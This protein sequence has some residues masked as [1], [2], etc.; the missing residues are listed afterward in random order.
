VSVTVTPVSDP[1]VANNDS[2]STVEDTS[3]L[4]DVAAND[5]DA[6]GDLDPTTANTSCNPTCSGP[7]NGT[8]VN[9]GNGTFTYTPDPGYQGG[10]S[11]V[12]EI[13]DAG[14]LCATASVAIT[15][16][17]ATHVLVGAGDIAWCTRIEDDQTADLL[18]NIPGT[19]FTTGDNA[20]PT[21]STADF[22]NCYD[23]TWGRPVD[24]ESRLRRHEHR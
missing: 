4:I 18:D 24:G 8:L 6:D 9:N 23:P 12:Y 3:V 11:F 10:D 21:G 2:A 22:N 7:S 5:T 14:G 13:C 19:V 15:V 1:P 16:S 17:P 20:Y